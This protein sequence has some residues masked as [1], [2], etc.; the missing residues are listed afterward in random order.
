[1]IA[2]TDNDD[3]LQTMDPNLLSKIQ[4]EGKNTSPIL[5][6]FSRVSKKGIYY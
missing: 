2:S 4:T 6:N 1:M 3:E 5:M